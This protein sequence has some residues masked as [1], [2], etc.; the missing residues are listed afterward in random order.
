M[1]DGVLWKGIRVFLAAIIAAILLPAHQ[2]S[3][4]VT[5]PKELRLKPL[6]CV[7]GALTDLTGGPP[8]PGVIVTILKDGA[9]VASVTSDGSGNFIVGE[10]KPGNYE[11]SVQAEPYRIFRTPIVVTKP[12]KRCR[13]R[14]AIFLD[15]GDLERCGSRVMKQ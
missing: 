15:V 13:R 7:C 3:G 12:E 1:L 10:L 9:E 5:C 11:L 14:L 8:L 6:R 4:E 2:S